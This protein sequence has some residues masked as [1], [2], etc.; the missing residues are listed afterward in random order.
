[1][2]IQD[3]QVPR[4]GTGQTTSL[5]GGLTHPR[6]ASEACPYSLA[7]LVRQLFVDSLV[8]Q[9]GRNFLWAPYYGSWSRYGSAPRAAQRPTLETVA[10]SSFAPSSGDAQA[11]T[12]NSTH[13]FYQKK[14]SCCH[15]V[16]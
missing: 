11:I 13:G 5:S 3:A 12:P 15:L 14:D 1:M 9:E 16:F 7:S 8:K 4:G 10:L 6:S 2:D